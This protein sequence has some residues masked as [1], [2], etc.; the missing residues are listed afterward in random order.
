MKGVL[1]VSVR[2]NISFKNGRVIKKIDE[3]PE[4]QRSDFIEKCVLYFLDSEEKE[5]VTR[6]DLEEMIQDYSRDV[7]IVN[8]NYVQ[9]KALFEELLKEVFKQ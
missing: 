4:G 1:D 6:S 7:C 9:M 2:K 5:Y 8:K 3:L